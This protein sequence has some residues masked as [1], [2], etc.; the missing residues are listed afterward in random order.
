MWWMLHC[1]TNPCM[2]HL[3]VMYPT[4]SAYVG[5]VGL[6]KPTGVL[7]PGGGHPS[8][9][10]T[11]RGAGCSKESLTAGGIPALGLRWAEVCVFNEWYVV[12]TGFWWVKSSNYYH[13]YLVPN[14]GTVHSSPVWRCVCWWQCLWVMQSVYCSRSL[15]VH[16]LSLTQS[17]CQ[18]IVCT[19]VWHSVNCSR[20]TAIHTIAVWHSSGVDR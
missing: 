4:T 19:A 16:V 17:G 18:S 10:H 9:Y 2:Y 5:G 6:L 14:T 20:V 7:D 13:L 1:W 8:K 15:L 3:C 12:I 11:G